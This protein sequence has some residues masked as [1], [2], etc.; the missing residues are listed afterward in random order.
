MNTHWL[1]VP[2]EEANKAKELKCRWDSYKRRWWKPSYVSLL[3][4]PEH[5]L[6]PE[7]FVSKATKAQR[8]RRASAKTNSVKVWDSELN[9]V[10]PSVKCAQEELQL[11]Y[12][13]LTELFALGRYKKI[14]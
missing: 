10:Y 9:I 12:K 1:N 4:I 2:Q 7:S 11:S 3:K 8:G 6:P 13:Q 14:N 5:W